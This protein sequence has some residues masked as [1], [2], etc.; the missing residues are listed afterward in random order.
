MGFRVALALLLAV[1]ADKPHGFRTQLGRQVFHAQ[2][3]Y[4]P[5]V[6]FL[7]AF[8]TGFT[9]CTGLPYTTTQGGTI[10][11]TRASDKWCQR[12]DGLMLDFGA[13]DVPAVE[14]DGILV[15]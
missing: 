9:E 1:T 5:P 11:V 2:S 3:V 15:E 7:K 14:A 10:T 12:S 13:S 4:V 8:E 6:P